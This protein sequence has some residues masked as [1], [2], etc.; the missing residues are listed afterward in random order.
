MAS[1]SSS[2][3]APSS[4]PYRTWLWMSIKATSLSARPPNDFPRLRSRHIAF[5]DHRDA[6]DENFLDPHRYLM[7]LLIGRP[8]GHRRRIEHH[9]IGEHAFFQHAA[10]RDRKAVRHRRSHLPDR[11]F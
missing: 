9:Y 5:V 11:I 7:R 1:E 8:V 6:I 4:N 10:I 2:V 3:R